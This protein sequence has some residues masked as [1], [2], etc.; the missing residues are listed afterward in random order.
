VLGIGRGNV[1]VQL[2]GPNGETVDLSAGDIVLL[3]AGTAHR[4]LGQSPDLIVVGAYPPGQRPDILRGDAG[5]R[6][7]ADRQIAIVPLPGTNPVTGDQ[8]SLGDWKTS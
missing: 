7:R 4:N 3:P 1:T 6:P 5:E 2:G 8:E